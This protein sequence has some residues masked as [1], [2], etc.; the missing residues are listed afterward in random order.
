MRSYK[1][2]LILNP[3]LSL[4]LSVLAGKHWS[5]LQSLSQTS[6]HSLLDGPLG[7]QAQSEDEAE[8]V[9]AMA[10][11]SVD[12]EQPSSIPDNTETSRSAVKRDDT[13]R[14]LSRN[15]KYTEYR[16]TV[17]TW[18]CVSQ[19]LILVVLPLSAAL[20]ISFLVALFT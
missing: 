1:E 7:A 5:C 10:S 17:Q 20:S 8:T 2:V 6:G 16:S 4:F 13:F 9:S 19:V 11:L 18:T 14:A 12:V 3:R 15:Q